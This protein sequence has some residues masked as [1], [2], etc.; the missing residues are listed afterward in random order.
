MEEFKKYLKL[1][2]SMKKGDKLMFNALYDL[3]R[4]EM[5]R[6]SLLTVLEIGSLIDEARDYM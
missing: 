6:A 1:V 2:I 3:A 5:K 4:D